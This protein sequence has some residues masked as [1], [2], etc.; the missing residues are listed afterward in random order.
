MLGNDD[1]YVPPLGHGFGHGPIAP[2]PTQKPGNISVKILLES[3][4]DQL[5]AE[6]CDDKERALALGGADGGQQG[7]K[8]RFDG[9]KDGSSIGQGLR[10]V[11]DQNRIAVVAALAL[12]GTAEGEC[13][14]LIEDRGS[15]QI[16][17]AYWNA[18][19]NKIPLGIVIKTEKGNLRVGKGQDINGA[20]K[21]FI[22]R[23]SFKGSGTVL[24]AHQGLLDFFIVQNLPGCQGEIP[25]QIF[26]AVA[27]FG[28]NTVVIIIQPGFQKTGNKTAY[29]KKRGTGHQEKDAQK[30]Y[31]NSGFQ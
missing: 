7:I 29:G 16:L 15:P 10:P 27:G 13:R 4:V 31:K 21:G 23:L 11:E 20:A 9:K 5:S 26:H 2:V 3:G 22:E 19:E 24:V 14:I 28:Q 30:G 18:A 17:G 1:M 6:V 25:K 8:T 12:A